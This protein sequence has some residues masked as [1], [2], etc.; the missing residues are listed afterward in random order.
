MGDKCASGNRRSERDTLA[1]YSVVLHS[2][3]V[4][5]K[6]QYTLQCQCCTP[7]VLCFAFNYQTPCCPPRT[8][9]CVILPRHPKH[10]LQGRILSRHC[11]HLKP[12]VVHYGEEIRDQFEGG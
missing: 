9:R 4:H 11:W 10:P 1:V 12:V 8:W 2:Y 7:T 5:C 3:C 6:V